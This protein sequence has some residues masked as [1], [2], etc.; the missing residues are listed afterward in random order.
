MVEHN[1]QQ[2]KLTVIS[3]LVTSKHFLKPQAKARPSFVSAVQLQLKDSPC[4]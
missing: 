3:P 2:K 1:W 4:P